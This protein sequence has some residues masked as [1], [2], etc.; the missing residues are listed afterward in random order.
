M[1]KGKD[2]CSGWMLRLRRAGQRTLQIDGNGNLAGLQPVSHLGW[3]IRGTSTHEH[4]SSKV[5]SSSGSERNNELEAWRNPMLRKT[6][7]TAAAAVLMFNV[8]TADCIRL[9]ADAW[10]WQPQ[11]PDSCACSRRQLQ[12]GAAGSAWRSAWRS[13]A[14]GATVVAAGAAV[15]AAATS[16]LALPPASLAW[17]QPLLPPML[18]AATAPLWPLRAR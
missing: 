16:G 10:K 13:V 12:G 18:P 3:W 9:Y 14:F 5:R 6:M 11:A 1:R 2:H 15:I 7:M 8:N 4:L 17:A